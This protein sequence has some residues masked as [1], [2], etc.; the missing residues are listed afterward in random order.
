MSDLWIG[1]FGSQSF[2]SRDIEGVVC[3][4]WREQMVGRTTAGASGVLHQ[5]KYDWKE[6][7]NLNDCITTV[8]LLTQ[9]CEGDCW[10]QWSS[11]GCQ[12]AQTLFLFH[13]NGTRHVHQNE[14]TEYKARAQI[15]CA[16][17][18][19]EAGSSPHLVHFSSHD[20]PPVQK[21]NNDIRNT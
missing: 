18:E 4:A 16:Y 20:Y 3:G 11:Q 5:P 10:E 8:L 1:P 13:P 9:W 14:T 17:L 2:L 6:Y 7:H 21:E 12:L 19:N 15:P